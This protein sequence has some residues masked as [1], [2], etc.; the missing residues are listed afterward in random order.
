[1]TVGKVFEFPSKPEQPG[2]SSSTCSIANLF[3]F[4]NFH[5]ILIRFG[6]WTDI[7]QKNNRISLERLPLL[8]DWLDQPNKADQ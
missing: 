5:S 3:N 4:Y 6:M 1:M 7:G 8:F 2:L